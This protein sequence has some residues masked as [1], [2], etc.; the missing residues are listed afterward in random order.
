MGSFNELMNGNFLY[1]LRIVL[2]FSIV[3]Y[4]IYNV[5]KFTRNT[6]VWTILKGTFVIIILW[7][8]SSLLGL[9]ILK[10]LLGQVLLYGMFVLL[11]IFQPELRMGLE[12]I[13][14]R[15]FKSLKVRNFF[16]K[17]NGTIEPYKLNRSEVDA[18]VES[19]FYMSK[20]RIGALISIEI[21]NNLNE[22]IKT[23]IPI[24]AKISKELLENI[25]TPN[26]PLHDGALI[27][28][29]GRIEAGSCYLPLS[30]S[31]EI[32]KELGTRHRAAI[33]LSERTDALTLIVS[34]ETGAISI[35][36]NGQLYRGL[37]REELVRMLE[38]VLLEDYENSIKTKG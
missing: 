38:L 15:S 22:Y 12:K 30:S 37:N 6:K 17:G 11:I 32:S 33:G 19:A 10:F 25:F 4:L 28:K 27:I 14:N 13:G 35:T 9:N 31:T 21:E 20:R 36:R 8:V 24:N 16:F 7:L 2:D 3:T 34:E 1:W 26:V 23:G 5:L 29:H 18:L